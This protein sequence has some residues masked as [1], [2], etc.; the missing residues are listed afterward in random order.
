MPAIR[1][2]HPISISLMP[3]LCIVIF[4]LYNMVTRSDFTYILSVLERILSGHMHSSCFK[5]KRL[6]CLDGHCNIDSADDTDQ[7]Y[8]YFL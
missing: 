3:K 2:S 4:F 8:I 7:E 1:C 5:S 6:V